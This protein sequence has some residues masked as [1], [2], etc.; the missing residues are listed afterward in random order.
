MG[1]L[2]AKRFILDDL[3]RNTDSKIKLYIS[4]A[5]P[6]LGSLIANFAAYLITNSQAA[7]LQALSESSTEMNN[8]WIQNKHLPK[9]FYAQGLYDTVVTQQSAIALDKDS[10]NVIYCDDDHFSIIIPKYKNVLVDALIIE[11]NNF[12]KDQNIQNIENLDKFSDDGQYDEE[13]FVLK[14]MMAHLHATL[15]TSSKLAFYNAEFTLRK[16]S[17][18]G[19]NLNSLEPLYTKIQELY[20]IEFGKLIAGIHKN[21]AELFTAVHEKIKEEDKKDLRSIYDSLQSLHKFGMLHQLAG[22]EDSIWW[23]KEHNAESFEI[24]KKSLGK[25]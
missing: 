9:R 1:G 10:Q 15:Q 19:V 23:D 14:L 20:Y 12:L 7:D 13:V 11:L 17:S 21:S 8:E 18:L 6:H 22:T 25:E 24:F 4:L 3:K 16:L 2:V 5:T